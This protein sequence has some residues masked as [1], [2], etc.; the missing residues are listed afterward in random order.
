MTQTDTPLRSFGRRKGRR[1]QPAKKKSLQR[2]L[3]KYA[4]TLNDPPNGEI[5]LVALFGNANPLQLEIGFGQGEHLAARA[6]TQ[7]DSNFIGCEPFINGVAN[8]C[9]EMEARDITN[10]R[11][12]PDDVWAVLRCLPAASVMRTEIL[13]PDPWPK[14]K[15]QKR[16]IVNRPLLD[17]LAH[18]QPVE[19]LLQLATDNADYAEWMLALLL[20]HPQWE[21]TAQS[22]ADWQQPPEDWA[23]TKYQLKNNKHGGDAVFITARRV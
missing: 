15:H 21:W 11:L 7:P 10:I 14:T 16:R 9:A 22:K 20:A 19:S 3:A 8:L 1:I 12:W 13:F 23:E 5:D 4:I 2:V 17:R 6:A 18:L